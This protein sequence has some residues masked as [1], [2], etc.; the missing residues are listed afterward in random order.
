MLTFLA[1]WLARIADA[2]TNIVITTHSIEAVK[3][4]SSILEDKKPQ[5]LLLSLKNGKLASKRLTL[6]DIKELE[7]AGIDIRMAEGILL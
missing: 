2:G 7:E 4:V 5:I 1:Q 3:M 6:N